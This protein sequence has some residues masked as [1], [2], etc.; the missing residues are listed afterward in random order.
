[1]IAYDLTAADIQCHADKAGASVWEVQHGNRTWRVLS[2]DESLAREAV[3]E[4]QPQE[5]QEELI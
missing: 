3:Q 2:H 4:R 5:P 1:M